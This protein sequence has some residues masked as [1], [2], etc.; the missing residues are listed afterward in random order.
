[1]VEADGAA[2]DIVGWDTGADGN[3]VHIL[4]SEH[5]GVLQMD[6]KEVFRRP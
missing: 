4:Y 6:G 3:Y 1:M 5:D 2:A